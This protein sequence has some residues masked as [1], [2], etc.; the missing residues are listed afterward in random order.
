MRERMLPIFLLIIATAFFGEM[1]VNPVWKF[2]SLF[3]RKRRFLF[4]AYLV[5]NGASFYSR[6]NNANRTLE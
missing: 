6:E 3:A 1:K 5:S 4:R 2:V